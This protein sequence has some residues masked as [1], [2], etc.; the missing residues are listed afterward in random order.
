M[1]GSSRSR[2]ALGGKFWVVH[3]REGVRYQEETV[4]FQGKGEEQ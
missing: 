3:V 2:R 4:I 1:D